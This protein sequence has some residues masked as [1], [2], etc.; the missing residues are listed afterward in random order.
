M[1]DHHDEMRVAPDASRAEELRLR[2]HARLAS[3][4]REEPVV[5]IQD[6]VVSIPSVD[7]D[8]DYRDGDIIVLDTED[9]GT[10]QPASPGRRSPPPGSGWQPRL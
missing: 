1:T 8:P 7:A 3:G 2:L 4:C 6:A 9:R 5:P 10:G